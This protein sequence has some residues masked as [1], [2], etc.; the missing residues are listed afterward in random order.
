MVKYASLVLVLSSLPHLVRD[1]D[2]TGQKE[3]GPDHVWVMLVRYG[4][5]PYNDLKIYGNYGDQPH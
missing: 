2:V 4:K 5:C 3:L 1:N